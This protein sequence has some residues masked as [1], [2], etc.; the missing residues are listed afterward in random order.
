MEC[1]EFPNE[2]VKKK[3]RTDPV[4]CSRDDQIATGAKLLNIMH[5]SYGFSGDLIEAIN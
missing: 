4:H 3:K 2:D 5:E 1:M